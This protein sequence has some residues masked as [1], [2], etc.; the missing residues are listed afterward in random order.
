[1]FHRPPDLGGA[2]S[3]SA[4]GSSGFGKAALAN[5]FLSQWRDR[6]GVAPNFPPRPREGRCLVRFR[7]WRSANGPELLRA[8]GIVGGEPRRAR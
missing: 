7:T 4:A 8:F 6:V 3:S 2:R 5:R 1:V